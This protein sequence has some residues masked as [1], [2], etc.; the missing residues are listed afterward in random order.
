MIRLF[1]KFSAG[2]WLAAAISLLTTP[3][4]TALIVP[5]E[6][7]RASMYILAL[8]LLLQVVMLGLDQSFARRF[9]SDPSLEHR[10]RLLWN[11]MLPP[12]GLSVLVALAIL[13]FG[14]PI[15]RLLIGAESD[16]LIWL[17]ALSV[18]VAVLERFA[19][20]VLRMNK[21][22]V[23]FSMLRLAFAIINFLVILLYCQFVARDFLAIVS[24]N[25]AALSLCA[26]LAILMGG[27]IWKAWPLDRA[28]IGAMLRYGLPFVPTFLAAWMFEGIDRVALRHYST[29]FELGLFSAAI[30]IVAIL[31]LLQIAFS[32]F[33]VPVSY[34]LY[35]SGS[36]EARATYASVFSQISGSLFVAGLGIIVLKDVVI[37]L[38]DPAYRGAA[39]IMP[40]LLLIPIMAT[41]SEVTVVGINFRNRTHW[42]LYIALGCAA[43]NLILNLLL[44]PS[45]GAKGAAIATGFSYI[46]FFYS[47]TLMSARLF[48]IPVDL[49]RVHIAVILFVLVAALNSFLPFSPLSYGAAAAAILAMLLIDRRIFLGLATDLAGR[50]R[51]SAA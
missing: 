25:L 14:S 45:L 13:W 3:I 12:L 34:E 47:R 9:Y 42:H 7:G 4:V 50:I 22:A 38:F 32:N 26:A 51:R 44:V 17:L 6:F 39:S 49:K 2:S 30:K 36:D 33:W 21:E 15:S 37:L 20:L 19:L 41:L 24:A 5:D 29:F 8:N 23:R 18:V 40:F 11:A 16:I 48:P 27:P 31:S 43:L 28:L 35:E 46:A 1:L 10:S